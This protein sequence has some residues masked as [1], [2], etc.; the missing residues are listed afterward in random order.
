MEKLRRLLDDPE[1]CRRKGE[2]L[3]ERA[4]PDASERI[5]NLIDER[6]TEMKKA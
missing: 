3:C 1:G 4:F 5:L 2:K 6:L